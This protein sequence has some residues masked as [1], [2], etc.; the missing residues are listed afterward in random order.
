MKTPQQQQPRHHNN[1][2]TR[3][4][5]MA[6]SFASRVLLR[7]ELPRFSGIVEGTSLWRYLQ[8]RFTW[9]STCRRS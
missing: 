6:G 5:Q 3:T 8:S 7:R 2:S 4:T 1:C 9:E